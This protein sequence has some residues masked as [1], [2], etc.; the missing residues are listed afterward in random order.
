MRLLAVSL[1]V[2]SVLA[3]CASKAPVPANPAPEPVLTPIEQNEKPDP[4]KATDAPEADPWQESRTYY[5][6][7]L[8]QIAQQ[9]GDYEV[10]VNNLLAAA[11]N[12]GDTRLF[13]QVLQLAQQIQRPDIGLRAANTWIESQPDSAD[14]YAWR[15][16][17]ELQL[18]DQQDA[19]LS[20]GKVLA[21]TGDNE[22]DRLALVQQFTR[23]AGPG[24][25]DFIAGIASEHPHPEWTYLALAM[26]SRHFGDQQFALGLLNKAMDTAPDYLRAPLVKAEIQ[27]EWDGEAALALLKDTY[28]AHPDDRQVQLALGRAYYQLGRFAEA[29]EILSIPA[30]ESGGQDMEARYLLAVS[31]HLSGRWSEAVPL[32]KQAIKADFQA[33]A[34]A[35]LCGQGFQRMDRPKEALACYQDVGPSHAQFAAAV[36]ARANLLLQQNQPEKALSMLEQELTRADDKQLGTLWVIKLE[37]LM[38]LER[39]GEAQSQL[40]QLPSEIRGQAPIEALALTIMSPDN[41]A[42]LLTLMRS[43]LEAL[44]EPNKEWILTFAGRLAEQHYTDEA[45]ALID[46]YLQSNPDDIEAL[47][48]RSLLAAQLGQPER[49]EADLRRLLTIDPNHVDALNALGY[50]LADLG[51]NLDE[52]QMLIERAYRAKPTSAA[53]LDSMGWLHYRLGKLEQARDYLSRAWALDDDAEIAAHYGE[54]LWKQGQRDEAKKVWQRA[55]RQQPDHAALKATM[56]RL[57]K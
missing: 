46:E 39:L 1:L 27:M 30:G 49:T 12:S 21:L 45:Y 50:T 18:R 51:R 54:V 5:Q 48:S 8:G 42:S 31:L 9:R 16:M 24:S 15:A 14:A 28:K 57:V 53:I 22:R 52:A 37:T 38:R 55:K 17:A 34:A 2:S 19:L 7:L 32:L 13:R 23:A 41:G 56:Q 35:W 25:V 3:G 4:A 11:Q 44:P 29:V 20:L 26:S 33:G 47:Y 36:Q 43:R 40:E 6:V 10:A